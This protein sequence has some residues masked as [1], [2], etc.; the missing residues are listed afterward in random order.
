MAEKIKVLYVDDEQNNLVG[1]KA[2]FRVDYQVYT[3]LS[4]DDGV[5]MLKQHP[6]IHIII[7]D[8]RMPVKSGVDFFEQIHE[9]Y[10]MAVRMILTGFADIQSVIEAINRGR[11]YR[12]INKPWTETEVRAAINEGYK[13]YLTSVLLQKKNA[14]LQKAYE[15]LNKF[16][17]S[18]THDVRG[19]IVSLKGAINVAKEM[20]DPAE[21]KT[22]LQMM[23]ESVDKLDSFIKNMH[24]YYSLKQGEMEIL[25][26]NF[27]D[28]VTTVKGMYDVTSR[29]QN[30]DFQV[31]IE[32]RDNFRSDANLLVLVL[33]NLLSNAFKYQRNAADAKFVK[34]RVAVEKGVASITVSDNGIGIEENHQKNIFDM[35][36]RASGENTG[37]GIGLYNVKDAL[38][39]LNGEIDVSSRTGQGT[40]FKL[41]IHSK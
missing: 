40:E 15:E 22:L 9:T 18:V 41:T 14:E 11:I 37:S 13:Y 29:M 16:A 39:K 24:T 25:E 30:I 36:Y 20:E 5:A 26:I 33:N 28:L 17:Y 4:A 27:A 7:S 35:F 32:Q 8:M 3:A 10:P 1:F 2:T 21:L 23:A 38:T 19:P 31:E 6:D 12:Y 34:L